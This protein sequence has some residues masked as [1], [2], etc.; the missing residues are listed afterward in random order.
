MRYFLRA[1]GRTFHV[2][3]SK[4]TLKL[5]RV[6]EL[7]DRAAFGGTGVLL[8]FGESVGCGPRG[9][10]GGV[11]A[12]VE[13]N[14][15][16]PLREYERSCSSCCGDGWGESM[17]GFVGDFAGRTYWAHLNDGWRRRVGCSS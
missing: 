14:C 17:S 13:G 10:S 3:S 16:W 2:G 7:S 5:L 4:L 8:R 1:A 9:L 12:D 15:D 6:S 11:D